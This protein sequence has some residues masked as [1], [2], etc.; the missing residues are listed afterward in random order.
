MATELITLLGVPDFGPSGWLGLGTALHVA[1]ALLLLQACWRARSCI[2]SVLWEPHDGLTIASKPLHRSPN[3]SPTPYQPQ[4]SSHKMDT[5]EK[6]S[7]A[8]VRARGEGRV[9][10]NNSKAHDS[11]PRQ[12]QQ[13]RPG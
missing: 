13:Q 2:L 11:G 1:R 10:H 4:D 3:T 6:D 9:C 8:Q 7:I 12:R 5:G